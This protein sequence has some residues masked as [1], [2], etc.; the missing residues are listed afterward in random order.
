MLEIRAH[1]VESI[2]ESTLGT[3][4]WLLRMCTS[5]Q[6]GGTIKQPQEKRK[7]GLSGNEL[8]TDLSPAHYRSN[9]LRF[10]L[11]SF[12]APAVHIQRIACWRI[13][14]GFVAVDA[15]FVENTRV[16]HAAFGRSAG[17]EYACCSNI[18]YPASITM[19]LT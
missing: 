2:D 6:D 16:K 19:F 5:G 3:T 11:A 8:I 7:L 13:L 4:L 12:G 9:G 17:S 14:H 15:R 10:M 1:V 18:D